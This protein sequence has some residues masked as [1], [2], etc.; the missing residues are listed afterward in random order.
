MERTFLRFLLSCSFHKNKV[1]F[2][3][4]V[5]RKSRNHKNSPILLYLYSL[6]FYSFKINDNT[7]EL[8][9]VLSDFD[10]MLAI[11]NKPSDFL[12]LFLCNYPLI[13]WR[14]ITQRQA[15]IVREVQTVAT[16]GF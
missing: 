6:N 7:T 9:V 14:I 13:P 3:L 4:L 16:L 15:Q 5:L 12:L 8:S 10:T 1:T 2:A 11:R